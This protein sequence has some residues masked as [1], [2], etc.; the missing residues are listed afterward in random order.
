[1]S[2]TSEPPASP[3]VAATTT[4]PR[5]AI[6]YERSTALPVTRRQ[7]RWLLILIALHLLITVQTTYVPNLTASAKQ[8]WT[9]R[10]ER[11]Q[12]E[13]AARQQLALERQVLDFVHPP[14]TVV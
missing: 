3:A 11:L 14:K 4:P 5:P 6:E 7:F 12:R 2:E 1:M 13:A 10:Q 8:W 9:E